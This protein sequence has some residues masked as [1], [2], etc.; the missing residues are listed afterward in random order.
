VH[1]GK[2]NTTPRDGLVPN[3]KLRLREQVREVMRYRHNSLRTEE[4]YWHWIRRYILFHG[5]RHPKDMAAAE[6]R[7]FLSQ[8]GKGT[9]I[10]QFF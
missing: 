9:S 5:K 1:I 4:A 6:V 10:A 3:P 8:A 7:M 2:T